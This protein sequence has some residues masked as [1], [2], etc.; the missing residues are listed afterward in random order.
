MSLSACFR[1]HPNLRSLK[2]TPNICDG[3]FEYMRIWTYTLPCVKKTII[4]TLEV[5]LFVSHR[6]EHKTWNLKEAL[7]RLMGESKIL[8][9]RWNVPVR[10]CQEPKR[11]ACQ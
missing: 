10:Q 9:L 8:G 6:L 2:T 11:K 4:E 5:V 1:I 7:K 3:Q